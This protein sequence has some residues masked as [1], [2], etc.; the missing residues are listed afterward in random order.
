MF[1]FRL[2]VYL[3]DLSHEAARA[4][5]AHTLGYRARPVRRAGQQRKYHLHYK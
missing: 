2:I 4:S 1:M 3:Y 5:P